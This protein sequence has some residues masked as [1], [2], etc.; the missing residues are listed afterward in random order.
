MLEEGD[1][2]QHHGRL[3]GIEAAY[4]LLGQSQVGLALAQILPPMPVTSRHFFNSLQNQHLPRTQ[5]S[6]A[7]H[8]ISPN[9]SIPPNSSICPS[10]STSRHPG[11]SP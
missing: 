9:P 1:G 7:S 8:S 11:V 6:P 2:S 4:A 10:P 3:N 5:A